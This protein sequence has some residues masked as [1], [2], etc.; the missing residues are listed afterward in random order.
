M[1]RA[2]ERYRRKKCQKN[3]HLKAI[4]KTKEQVDVSKIYLYLP[5]R[6]YRLNLSN[7]L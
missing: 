7:F 2:N 3:P 5:Y 4:E 6:V 1:E